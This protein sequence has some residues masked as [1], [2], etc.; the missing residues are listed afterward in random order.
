LLGLP[1]NLTP[2]AHFY[3]DNSATGSLLLDRNF[4]KNT[5]LGLQ[6]AAQVFGASNQQISRARIGRM[7]LRITQKF[8]EHWMLGASGAYAAGM[9][10]DGELSLQGYSLAFGLQA[11]L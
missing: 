5:A 8:S 3:I 9:A 10:E 4:G 7:G 11:R 1:A 6:L 2:P